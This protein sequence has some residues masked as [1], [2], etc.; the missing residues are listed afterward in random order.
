M[1]IDQNI[2]LKL[3]LSYVFIDVI[4]EKKIEHEQ[5]ELSDN[6]VSLFHHFALVD[7]DSSPTNQFE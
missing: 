2:Y 1:E 6:D 5:I 7:P 4:K 3:K